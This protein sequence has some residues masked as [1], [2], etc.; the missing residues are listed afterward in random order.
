MSSEYL[1]SWVVTDPITKEDL[2]TYELYGS[3]FIDN[4]II[5]STD[6]SPN[7]RSF[8]NVHYVTEKGKDTLYDFNEWLN[9]HNINLKDIAD[10]IYRSYKG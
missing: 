8:I 4:R 5:R 1:A 6:D 7:D 10:H 3:I 9:K 2:E